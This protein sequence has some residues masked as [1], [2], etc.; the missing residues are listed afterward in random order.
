MVLFTGRLFSNSQ[1]NDNT[2]RN[3]TTLTV[4][5]FDAQRTYTHSTVRDATAEYS[6]YKR[7]CLLP[8]PL[9]GTWEGL[10]DLTKICGIMTCISLPKN[11]YNTE[12]VKTH[13][14]F[15]SRPKCSVC[16]SREQRRIH[17]RKKGSDTKPTPTG[18][19]T[20]LHQSGLTQMQVK[21]RAY[22]L[23]DH[24]CT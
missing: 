15:D 7:A 1:A 16:A 8:V 24:M 5:F 14:P 3:G 6:K 13:A 22:T 19:T 11:L 12:V 23:R 2:D 18:R 21:E 4:L 17:D 10:H 20:P 9:P